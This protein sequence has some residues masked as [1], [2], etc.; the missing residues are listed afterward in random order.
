MIDDTNRLIDQ[1]LGGLSHGNVETV[2]DLISLPQKVRGYGPVK[3]AAYAE[4]L[5]A[6]DSQLETL[7]KPQLDAVA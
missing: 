3:D 5:A 1:A 2:I 6:R 7:Q 4:F